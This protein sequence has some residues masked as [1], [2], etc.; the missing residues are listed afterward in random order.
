M[1]ERQPFPRRSPRHHRLEAAAAIH[2][3]TPPRYPP[4]SCSRTCSAPI[5]RSQRVCERSAHCA[6]RSSVRSPRRALKSSARHSGTAASASSARRQPRKPSSLRSAGRPV[7][8]TI[9]ATS[10]KSRAS[11][12][13]SPKCHHGA[14]NSNI[15]P[16]SRSMRVTAA[17]SIATHRT[18]RR[19][20][21]R[22]LAARHRL[23]LVATLRTSGIDLNS[24]S[25]CAH[26]RDRAKPGRRSHSGTRSAH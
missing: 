7:W 14:C 24:P 1:K 10:G 13:A 9:I 19:E 6:P 3:A 18:G 25:T 8:F 26:P 20:R 4:E 17:P 21:R 15:R 2:R 12:A 16:L 22:M 23:R 11:S 5:R